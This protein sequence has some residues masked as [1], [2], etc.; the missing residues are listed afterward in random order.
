M[1]IDIAGK[2]ASGKKLTDDEIEYA[3]DR[4][5]ELPDE[6]DAAVKSYRLSI[7]DDGARPPEPV[8]QT[9]PAFASP[10]SPGLFL[11]EDELGQMTKDQLVT[12]GELK[13]QDLSGT[14]AE[15]VAALAGTEV[16]GESESDEDEG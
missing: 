9:G 16:A 6:Y 8:F 13:D 3:S 10:A 1:S 15:M 5:I 4:G 7:G 11:S 12:L 14:K 2:L